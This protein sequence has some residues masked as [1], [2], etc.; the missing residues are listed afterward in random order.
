MRANQRLVASDGYEVCLFPLEYMDISQG[1]GGS[2]SHAGTLNIDFVG[3]GP[4]GRIY[5]CPYYAPVSCTCVA[6]GGADNW[7]VFTSTNQVHLANGT[8]SYITWVQMHDNN[9]PSV[10]SSYNQ[11]DLIGHTG[12]AGNVT[13]DHVHL[14]FALGT[15]A[16]WQQVTSG[17]YQ[18]I[19][20]IH[21]YDACYVNDT[22]L[23]DDFNY[24]WVEYTGPI[25]PT[26][27][28]YKRKKFPWVLYA[29]KLR[30][31]RY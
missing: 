8:L 5:N 25:P 16:G 4:N 19:N 1:E 29:N 2:Y 9:P 6:G 7:R 27:G 3:V 17:Q 31:R 15:Y 26:P 22:V 13:G 20:S 28:T 23:I 14:N 10:G 30:N 12:T 21:V 11:G 18:L 24:P